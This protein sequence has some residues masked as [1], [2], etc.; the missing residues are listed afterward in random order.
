MPNLARESAQHVSSCA[1][2]ATL[3]QRLNTA[4]LFDR[5]TFVMMNVFGRSLNRP[6]RMGRD[7]LGNHHCTVISRQAGAR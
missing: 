1:A 7:H 2:I 6:M 3:M 5:V 4:K